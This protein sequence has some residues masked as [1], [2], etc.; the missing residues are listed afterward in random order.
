MALYEIKA[1][2]INH[3]PK[4]ERISIFLYLCS[5]YNFSP[6]SLIL[7]LLVSQDSG[8]H[9][10]SS[11]SKAG[12][13]QRTIEVEENLLS[14][15]G[16]RQYQKQWSNCPGWGGV[17]RHNRHHGARPFFRARARRGRNRATWQDGNKLP[18]RHHIFL[19]RNI[20]N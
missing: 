9:M 8:R 11:F 2:L 19:H 7:A 18:G 4:K 20:L 14:I 1:C 3:S 16:C 15:L 6:V 13:C 17:K 12:T 5:E 10:E